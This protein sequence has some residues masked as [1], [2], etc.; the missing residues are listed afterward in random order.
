MSAELA[1]VRALV[2]RLMERVERL[3]RRLNDLEPET[4]TGV[5]A[6]APSSEPP[7]D[8]RV[9]AGPGEGAILDALGDMIDGL[10]FGKHQGDEKDG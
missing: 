3:E 8:P 9:T 5:H 4:A 10:G 1:V 6:P 7:F 2:L